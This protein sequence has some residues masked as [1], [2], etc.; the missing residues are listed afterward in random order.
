VISSAL[1]G[2]LQLDRG[3]PLGFAHVSGLVQSWLQ[4]AGGFAMVGLVV[5]L[6]YAMAT[7][8]DKSQS[9]KIRVPVTQWMIVMA[10][11]ALVCY[12]GCL[13]LIALELSGKSAF[14][15]MPISYPVPV[16]QPGAPNYVPPPAFHT[17]LLPMLLM[18]AGTF[19]LLGICEP[20][21]RDGAKIARRNLSLGFT[22][23][24]RFGRSV[25]TTV[26][27][28]FSTR[29]LTLIG[30]GLG[31]YAALGVALYALGAERLFGIWAGWLFVALA[32]LV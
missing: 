4:D 10:A 11:L 20:F 3:D 26:A 29:R 7:P 25:S 28:S 30:I 1:F 14:L 18:I 8:T 24:R 19:A 31:V 17:E 23:V 12:A 5:Y 6:L 32:V 22:G 27:T 16:P 21:A 2:I 13:G 15:K 9:E